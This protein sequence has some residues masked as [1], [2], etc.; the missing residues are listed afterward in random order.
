VNIY[1]TEQSFENLGVGGKKESVQHTHRIYKNK[2]EIKE[3]Y[4]H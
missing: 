1:N 2:N 4:S 3:Q